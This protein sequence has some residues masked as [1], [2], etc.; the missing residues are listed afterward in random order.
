MGCTYKTN[1]FG[2]PLLNIVGITSTYSTFNAG[3]VFL[4]EETTEW[5]T[6]ALQC[7][8]NVVTPVVVATDR[9][10]ALMNAISIVFPQT[11]NVLCIWHINKNIL[12]HT[13]KHF[14]D[15]NEFEQFLQM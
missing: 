10:L 13:R 3:F 12:T 11:K 8:R 5:Y 1:R 7:F 2:L 9:E 6:W 14:N 4:R 15:S